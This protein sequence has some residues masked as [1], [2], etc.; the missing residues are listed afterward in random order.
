MSLLMSTSKAI[1][2]D[3]AEGQK[4]SMVARGAVASGFVWIC[5]LWV[6]SHQYKDLSRSHSCAGS[7][8][9]LWLNKWLNKANPDEGGELQLKHIDS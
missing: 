9:P 4:A 6:G 5:G 7:E 2:S 3:S 1:P 8:A